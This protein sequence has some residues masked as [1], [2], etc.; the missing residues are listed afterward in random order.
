[1]S[2]AAPESTDASA[3]GQDDSTEQTA[4]PTVEDLQAQIA[5]LTKNS[6]KWEERAKANGGAAKAAEQARLDAMSESERAIEEARQ[7]ARSEAASTFGQ[8][9]ARTEFD[10]LAGRRNPDFDTASALEYVDLA[11][12]LD[13]NGE[14]DTAAIGAA[15]QRLV[16]EPAGWHPELRRW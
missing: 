11:K 4:A 7:A 16:P 2:E 8:R 6:R 10:N 15:V 14:P 13:E 9:L 1:M 12:F 5:E 3:Q